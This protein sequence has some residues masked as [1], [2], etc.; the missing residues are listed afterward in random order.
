[1]LETLK[2]FYSLKQF[3]E[4]FFAAKEPKIMFPI[5]SK[6]MKTMILGNYENFSD[7]NNLLNEEFPQLA[8]QLAPQDSAYALRSRCTLSACL[9]IAF[10]GGN[11]CG[12]HFRCFVVG[13]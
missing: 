10:F 4:H 12:V 5:H 2:A 11:D 8:V 7:F 6:K 3:N 1:M 13:G 9:R